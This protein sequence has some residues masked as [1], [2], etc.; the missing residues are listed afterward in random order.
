MLNLREGR[1]SDIYIDCLEVDD[2]G[3]EDPDADMLDLEPGRRLGR[4][5]CKMTRVYPNRVLF[6]SFRGI[7]NRESISLW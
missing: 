1:P 7:V 6:N 4:T 2:R 3:E 5:V